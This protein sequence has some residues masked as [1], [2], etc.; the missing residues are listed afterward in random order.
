MPRAHGRFTRAAAAPP[1]PA[2]PIPWKAPWH[3]NAYAGGSNSEA[4][5]AERERVWATLVANDTPQNRAA[6]A[7]QL[8]IAHQTQQD[9]GPNGQLY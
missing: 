3:N 9:S 1:A 4:I 7:H 5:Q 6:Y 2:D 8:E